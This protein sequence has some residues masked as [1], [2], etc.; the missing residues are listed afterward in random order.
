VAYGGQAM[1]Q[2]ILQATGG[3]FPLAA[4][5]WL[6]DDAGIEAATDSD[7]VVTFDGTHDGQV[8][9]FA[10]SY[11]HVAQSNVIRDSYSD[12]AVGIGIV[13]GEVDTTGR[14]AVV[15]LWNNSAS[16]PDV[17]WTSVTEVL[18]NTASSTYTSIAWTATDGSAVTPDPNPDS[19]NNNNLIV[20]S[21]AGTPLA[22]TV[23]QAVET[24]T[25]QA[26]AGAKLVPVEQAA[27][28]DSAQAI[29]ANAGS[30]VVTLGQASETDTAQSVTPFVPGLVQ[31][32]QASETDSAGSV[33]P[34][35]GIAV[36]QAA[37]TDTAFAIGHIKIVQLGQASETDTARRITIPS[38]EDALRLA[39]QR[40][41]GSAADHAKLVHETRVRAELMNALRANIEREDEEMAAIVP[42]MARALMSMRGR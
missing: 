41:S 3:G 15:A 23:N 20:L 9:V 29:T 37:E 39:R 38:V 2:A 35:V 26:I 17:A 11:E 42:A 32:G 28:T 8:R 10:A 31:V 33:T 19:G 14:G 1:T 12:T 4:S 18:E 34:G 5:F 13:P 22:V 21:L 7:V 6:L 25:A 36:G 40:D 30:Q 16:G 24:D 27:E